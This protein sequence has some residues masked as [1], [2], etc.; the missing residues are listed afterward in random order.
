[1]YN[2][3][4]DWRWILAQHS[5]RFCW[6]ILQTDIQTLPLKCVCYR[7]SL[8]N[9]T[10]GSF[11]A[12]HG[13]A[14]LLV[15][16]LMTNLM[17]SVCRPLLCV[18]TGQRAGASWFSFGDTVQMSVDWCCCCTVCCYNM[19]VSYVCIKTH[20][21]ILI[22]SWLLQHALRSIV[23]SSTVSILLA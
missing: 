7:N 21:R 20:F 2:A 10:L 22:R 3:L 16:P 5:L 4:R 15:T 19:C 23:P 12:A 14:A 17:C 9:R 18:K 11:W 1:M 8:C 6:C 13:L